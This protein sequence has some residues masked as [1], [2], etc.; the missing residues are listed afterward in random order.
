MGKQN[1]Y[2][3]SVRVPFMVAGP[4]LAGGELND[5][6]L[7]LQ[8]LMATSLELAQ[9]EKPDHVQF[10]SILPLLDGSGKGRDAIYGAYLEAQRMVTYGDYKLILY[11]KEKVRR[12]YNIKRD[13]KEMLDLA[14]DGSMP[15]MRELFA[16]L[17]ELQKEVGDKLD[18]KTVYP[19]LAAGV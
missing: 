16:K 9:I 15:I 10:E 19:E 11:P 3:H 1:M 17:L 4:G 12:L 2:D 8:D 18:V 7:Y 6:P 14:G 5:T 13:P